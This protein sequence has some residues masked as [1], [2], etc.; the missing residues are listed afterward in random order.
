MKLGYVLKKCIYIVRGKV[1]RSK[2][3]VVFEDVEYF[4]KFMDVE[5][6]ISISY[7]FIV[8]FD[9]RKYNKFDFLFIISDF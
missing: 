2:D 3:K 1:F 9:E 7:Y 6:N 4:E 5:W 8:I